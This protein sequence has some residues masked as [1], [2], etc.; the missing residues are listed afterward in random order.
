MTEQTVGC[1]QC[2]KNSRR[3]TAEQFTSEGWDGDFDDVVVFCP[4][5]VAQGRQTK[6]DFIYAYLARFD[7]DTLP[8]FEAEVNEVLARVNMMVVNGRIKRPEP[9]K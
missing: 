8:D 1:E 6:A 2:G 4:E 5:C 9:T 7:Q 3:V